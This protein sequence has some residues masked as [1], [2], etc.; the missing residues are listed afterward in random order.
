MGDVAIQNQILNRNI[1]VCIE[2]S[3]RRRGDAQ[4]RTKRRRTRCRI[5]NTEISIGTRCVRIITV[6][7]H[8]FRAVELNYSKPLSRTSTDSDAV[9][10]WPN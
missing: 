7:R 9:A 2:W 3:C 8:A 5:L 4:D 1:V 6:N 10:R